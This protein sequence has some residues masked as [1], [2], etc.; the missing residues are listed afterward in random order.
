MIE[1]KNRHTDAVIC[2]YDIKTVNKAVEKAVE[3][4]VN[5]Y[6]ANLYG[7]RLYGAYLGGANLRGADLRGANLGG[8]NLRGADLRGADLYG[9]DLRGAN[10]YGVNLRGADLRGANLYDAYLGGAYLYG[11]KLGGAKNIPPL[12]QAQNNILPEGQIIGWK[13]LKGGVIAK[14]A[15]PGNANRVNCIGSRKCRAEM[16]LVMDLSEG[17]VGYDNHTGKTEYRIGEFVYP[18]HFDDSNLVECSNGIHFFIT[19]IEAENF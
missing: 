5:L 14:L 2:S 13:K 3:D 15:I 12:A 16:A 10:L 19:R 18:D 7:V 4:G 11:A 9:A 8:A 6:G 1:I 17:E